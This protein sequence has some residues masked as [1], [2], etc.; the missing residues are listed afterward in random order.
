MFDPRINRL[1]ILMI[2]AL[3]LGCC[4]ASLSGTLVALGTPGVVPFA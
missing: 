1:R 4:S 2:A 3:A